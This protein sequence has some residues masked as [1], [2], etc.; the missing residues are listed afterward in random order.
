MY[1]IRFLPNFAMFFR[2]F[3]NSEEFQGFTLI[4]RL[5]NHSKYQ[6]PCCVK[7]FDQR[8]IKGC[9][10]TNPIIN[11]KSKNTKKYPKFLEIEIMQNTKHP[12]VW[13]NYLSSN[14]HG[15]RELKHRRFWT[16]HVKRKW[17]FSSDN[18]PWRYR[19][20]IAKCLNSYRDDLPKNLFKITAQE[21][22]TSISGWRASLKNV[23]A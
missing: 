10:F 16:T 9:R 12:L 18:K 23:A 13:Y 20:Y 11:N 6:K 15:N 21:C 7:H 17:A 14:L 2:V 8:F 3:V 22:E 4:S 5:H 19:I 1:L